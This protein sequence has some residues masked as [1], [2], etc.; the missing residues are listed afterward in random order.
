[1]AYRV[2]NRCCVAVV[3]GE[4]SVREGRSGGGFGTELWGEEP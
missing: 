1:V 4:N 3:E 2:T